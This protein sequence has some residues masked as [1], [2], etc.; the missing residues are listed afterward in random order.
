[1]ENK[2]TAFLQPRQHFIPK[3][4]GKTANKNQI[5][6]KS[7]PAVS[8]ISLEKPGCNRRKWKV[9]LPFMILKA[10]F[11]PKCS[12]ILWQT[13][14][15]FSFNSQPKSAS[16]PWFE[17]PSCC[18]L[19]GQI[20]RKMGKTKGQH[21][22]TKYRG[23][24]RIAVLC[25]RSLFLIIYLGLIGHSVLWRTDGKIWFWEQ[26]WKPGNIERISLL[27]RFWG[28]ALWWRC[29]NMGGVVGM[30]EGLW[31]WEVKHNQIWDPQT[32][33]ENLVLLQTS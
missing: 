25:Y 14:V 33:E 20:G 5:R 6:Q 10:P 11:S 12:V 18:D 22:L 27:C 1:M 23:P 7:N 13:S 4:G 26:R 16:I 30:R 28:A 19:S 8:R 24:G 21:N 32:G 29:L 31:N 3:N 15:E 9:S 2:E 17:S